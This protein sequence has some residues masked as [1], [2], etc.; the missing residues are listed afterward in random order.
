MHADSST[1]LVQVDLQRINSSIVLRTT[2]TVH[3]KILPNL[4]P[5]KNSQKGQCNAYKIYGHH[6]HNC[7]FIAPHLAMQAFVQNQPQLCKQILAN[8]IS[9]N[10]EEHKRTIV[11]T[12]QQT[13]VLDD[14]EDSDSFMNIAVLQVW[15]FDD[16]IKWLK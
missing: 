13:E 11:R 8:H 2:Q 16:N 9:P 15:L 7:R 14:D 3:K 1:I 5:N 10:T 6:V 12:M 4:P